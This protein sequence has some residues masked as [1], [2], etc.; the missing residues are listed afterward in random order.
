MLLIIEDGLKRDNLI[1]LLNRKSCIKPNGKA[2][3]V[4]TDR[5][6]S[7][8]LFPELRA[9]NTMYYKLDLRSKLNFFLLSNSNE[10]NFV[11]ILN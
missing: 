6:L 7:T 5:S 11:F 8:F 4:T 1:M 9:R 2:C 10:E 3:V